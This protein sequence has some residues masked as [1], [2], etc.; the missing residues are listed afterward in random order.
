MNSNE[1]KGE[2]LGKTIYLIRHAESVNNV[3][4]RAYKEP[5]RKLRMPS[6]TQVKTMAPMMALPM[7]T[8]LSEKGVWQVLMVSYSAWQ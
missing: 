4:K 7:N 6:W 3:S 5:L 8:P 1:N 2:N